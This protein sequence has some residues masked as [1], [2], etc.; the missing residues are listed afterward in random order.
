VSISV[1]V[2]GSSGAVFAEVTP[3]AVASYADAPSDGGTYA[4]K[5]GDWTE[6]SRPTALRAQL[7]SC[8][9]T[10]PYLHDVWKEDDGITVVTDEA[11]DA[12]L[13]K[14][15]E[16]DV[17]ETHFLPLTGPIKLFG[18]SADKPYVGGFKAPQSNVWLSAGHSMEFWTDAEKIQFRYPTGVAPVYSGAK[19]R[20]A[21]IIVNDRFVTS[22]PAPEDEDELTVTINLPSAGV[23]RR[24][25]IDAAHAD[26]VGRYAYVGASDTLWKP[27]Q[28]LSFGIIGDSVACGFDATQNSDGYANALTKMLGMRGY[29]CAAPGTGYAAKAADN[30]HNTYR[31][32]LAVDF[33][34]LPL[35]FIVVQGSTNDLASLG[36]SFN[37]PATLAAECAVFFP[38]LRTLYPSVPILVTSTPGSIQNVSA[39]PTAAYTL[40]NSTIKAA[41]DAW[42]DSN[43]RW[44]SFV[45]I[46]GT[47][48]RYKTGAIHPD[49]DGH[50]YMATILKNAIREWLG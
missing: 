27:Q 7:Q 42:G 45:D 47:A 18:G 15:Y 48:G 4:R 2:T 33:T 22:V 36:A 37:D 41:F 39:P 46:I 43:S 14:T 21:R 16:I 12:S 40:I 29:I 6:V 26:S 11:N 13:S 34:G 8:D 5:D 1:S 28:R 23:A 50:I 44:L 31:E 38:A 10:D 9:S 25:R 17:A 19:A 24:I 3:G 32:R 35:S 30:A 20:Q 49:T